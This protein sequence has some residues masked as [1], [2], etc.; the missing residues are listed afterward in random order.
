MIAG[1]AY[2]YNFVTA[3]QFCPAFFPGM[4]SRAVVVSSNSQDVMEWL[5][6]TITVPFH[7]EISWIF[8]I[9]RKR[10]DFN[11]AKNGERN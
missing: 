11:T 2:F 4:G 8:R 9:F 3:R 10:L 7:Q 6:S 1:K 5:T